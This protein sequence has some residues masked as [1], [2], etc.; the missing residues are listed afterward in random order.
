MP[1]LEPKQIQQEVEKGQ[2][3]NFYFLFGTEMMKM[4]ELTKRI[5]NAY[6]EK[7]NPLPSSSLSSLNEIIL[8]AS[9]T[10]GLEGGQIADECDSM[11]LGVSHKVV[12]VKNAHTIKEADDLFR[13]IQF[14][15]F[16]KDTKEPVVLIFWSKDLDLRKKWIKKCLDE[17]AV[18]ACEDVSEKERPD[19]IRYLMK[20]RGLIKD[21]TQTS[22]SSEKELTTEEIQLVILDCLTLDPW[23]LDIVDQ[24]LERIELTPK[25]FIKESLL[26]EQ[27]VKSKQLFID[28]FFSK[29]K[30]SALY[31]VSSFSTLPEE[32]LPMVGLLSWNL[33]EL[34]KIKQNAYSASKPLSSFIRDKFK[35]YL[36]HWTV[37]SLQLASEKLTS[38]DAS[39]K[40]SGKDA[41]ASW[42]SYLLDVL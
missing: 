22:L 30:K 1:K 7:E 11:L 39:L 9:Q 41:H 37:E 12:L 14:K 15:T 35:P 3:R 2:F 23:G 42:C 32:S 28:S 27:S 38:F 17:A 13:R 4:R 31:H 34:T 40:G 20:R 5:K 8:D 33:R 29:N 25:E 10:G 18:V 26:H 21:S 19:W 24:A 6:L 36:N 16:S